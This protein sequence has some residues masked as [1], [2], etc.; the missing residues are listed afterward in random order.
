MVSSL[1]RRIP[2]SSTLECRTLRV[3]QLDLHA[4]SDKVG[5][6]VEMAGIE[7]ASKR[8]CDQHTTSLVDLN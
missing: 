8:Y 4:A 6:A 3:L 2:S 7:P 1:R 5:I